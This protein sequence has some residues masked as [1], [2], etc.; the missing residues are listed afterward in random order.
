MAEEA[1]LVTLIKRKTVII[2]VPE[3]SSTLSLY[4]ICLFN[5]VCTKGSVI[6]CLMSIAVLISNVFDTSVLVVLNVIGLEVLKI[7]AL[8]I[9]GFNS[10]AL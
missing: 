3:D 6:I 5:S 2:R 8:Y 7:L 1:D 10:V 9:R 4:L